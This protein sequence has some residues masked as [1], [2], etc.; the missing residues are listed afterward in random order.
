MPGRHPGSAGGARGLQA[1]SGPSPP[2]VTRWQP[3]SQTPATAKSN[4]GDSKV[5]R[6]RQQS[7]TPATAMSDAGD[8]EMRASTRA[9]DREAGSHR[10]EVQSTLATAPATTA[11]ALCLGLC[12]TTAET[13]RAQRSGA[14]TAPIARRGERVA[15][16]RWGG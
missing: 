3:Q 16:L 4:A 1:V 6:G 7:Q 5:K 8:R 12:G 11:L 13:L 9:G 14:A 10:R 15:C 2:A